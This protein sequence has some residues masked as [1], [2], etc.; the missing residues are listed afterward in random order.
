MRERDRDRELRNYLIEAKQ[1]SNN[2]EEESFK[3]KKNVE[4]QRHKRERG[5]NC[6]TWVLGWFIRSNCIG[7]I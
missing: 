2:V 5:F 1:R 7:L 4:E 3:K 6:L